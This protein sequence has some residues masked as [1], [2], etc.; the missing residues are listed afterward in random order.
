MTVHDQATGDSFPTIWH[1]L[2]D[3]PAEIA[4]LQMRSE[5]MAKIGHRVKHWDIIQTEA[6]S[7]L[8]ITQPR[9]NDL[10]RGRIGRF[11]VDALL[12]IAT[13]AGIGVSLEL[14]DAA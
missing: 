10:L 4:S 3:D 12:K 14:K 7:K 11:S 13:K 1:S 8:G 6:A 2:F 5:L 9:L